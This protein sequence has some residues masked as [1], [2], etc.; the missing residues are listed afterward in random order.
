MVE[1]CFDIYN[2]KMLLYYKYIEEKGFWKKNDL[3]FR[4]HPD[5]ALFW[6]LAYAF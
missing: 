5:K 1:S 3:E 4:S 6:K 2:E